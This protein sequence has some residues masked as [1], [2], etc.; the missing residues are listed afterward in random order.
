M[1][2]LLEHWI[3]VVALCISGFLLYQDHLKPF[4]LA[5]RGAGRITI[6]RNPWS[7]GLR[8]SCIEIDLIFTNEGARRG[9]VE[10][11]AVRLY[12]PHG[13]AFFRSYG[14]AIDRQ[15][16]LQREL[17]P[18]RL[19]MFIGFEL[20]KG[21]SMVRR[22]LLV[23]H[24]NSIAFSFAPIS[25]A[26]EIWVRSTE[27]PDWV[28]YDS[29]GFTVD[30]EDIDTLARSKVTPQPDGSVFVEWLT[31][32]K[33]ADQNDKRVAVLEERLRKSLS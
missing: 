9:V 10:D 17:V 12:D 24:V 21:E 14:V 22:I 6:A 20:S 16:N 5:V 8:Q 28:R 19:E 31:R 25:Y 27:A 15:L 2:Y 4:K 13:G 23:P 3:A 1:A 26:A 30:Q 11:V 33:V 29:F 32:D 7:E 18:P